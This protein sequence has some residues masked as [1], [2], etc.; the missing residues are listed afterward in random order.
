MMPAETLRHHL[1]PSRPAVRR[2]FE[3]YAKALRPFPRKRC[4]DFAAAHRIILETSGAEKPGPWSNDV[5]P[6]LVPIMD[7]MQDALESGK[8]GVVVKKSAQGGGSEAVAN[9]VYWC[10]RYFPG[11]MLYLISKDDHAA[12]FGRERFDL[13]ACCT[14]LQGLVRTGR[15]SGELVHIKR[16]VNGKLVL[17]GGRSVLN[18][19]SFPYRIVV[20][21]EL[22]SLMADIGGE[23]DP[24]AMAQERTGAFSG[25]TLVVAFAHPTTSDRGV[26]KLYEQHSDQRRAFAPC[27]HCGEWFWLQW[28]HVQVVPADG[29]TKDQAARDPRY[30]RYVTPCCKKELTDAQRSAMA[31]RTEQRSTLAPDVA[32]RCGWVGMHFSQL[33]MANKP[34]REL[35]AERIAAEGDEGRMKVFVNK[36]LGDVYVSKIEE[37]SADDWRR[38]IGIPRAEADPLVHQRGEVPAPVLYLTAGQDSKSDALH[39][40]V[41]GWGFVRDVAGAVHFCGWLIDYGEYARPKSVTLD[42]SELSVFDSVFYQKYWMSRDG[43]VGHLVEQAGH[44][45]SWNEVAVYDYC[46]RNQP[47]AVP[48]RGAAEDSNS[49]AP[50]LRWGASPRW[51]VA[52]QEVTDPGMKLCLL[53]TYALKV[54]WYGLAKKS[55]DVADGKGPPR[56]HARLTLP[57]DTTEALITHFGNEYLAPLPKGKGQAWKRKGDQHWLDCSVYA[58]GLG[59]NRRRVQEE[60]PLAE[61]RERD[62]SAGEVQRRQDH[63]R[64]DGGGSWLASDQRGGDWI[65]ER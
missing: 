30:Y 16:L 49:R 64:P 57:A 31:R 28:D 50:V 6:Y 51:R 35:A 15:G 23:G 55:F 1:T 7:G 38:C 60:L 26:G 48:V 19:Q 11:P 37:T 34:L 32:A 4:S 46:Q 29:L 56:R 12:E 62:K 5:F 3:A 43:A 8:K 36:K 61:I 25:L 9:F 40:A 17:L 45:A 21:D 42:A 52:G 59:L 20:I 63:D 14:A 58:F 39:W 33:Y 47:R 18:L 44:D 65:R 41:W 27:P 53:N 10:M 2:I 24:V 22:D 13:E 54:D